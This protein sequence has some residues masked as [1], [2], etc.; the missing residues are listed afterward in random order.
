MV[1]NH[2]AKPWFGIGV[3]RV[4]SPIH[5]HLINLYAEVNVNGR[6]LLNNPYVVRCKN[7]RAVQ[8]RGRKKIGG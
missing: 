8:Y 3:T 5:L 6:E 2:S 7:E 4:H 1:G